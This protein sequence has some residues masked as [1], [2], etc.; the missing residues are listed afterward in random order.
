MPKTI[1]VF[2]AT[3]HQGGAVARA[4]AADSNNFIVRGITR[5]VQQ[6]VKVDDLKAAGVTVIQCDLDNVNSIRMALNDADG[7][8]IVTYTDFTEPDCIE[9]EKQRGRNI[10][11]ACA[12]AGVP[13]VIYSTQ[14]HTTR[15]KG[16]QVR[17]LVAKAEIEEYMKSKCL[18]MTCFLVPCY[19]ENF[20]DILKPRRVDRNTFVLEIPMGE[21]SL[22]LISVE[23]VGQVART[24]FLNKNSFLDKTISLCGEKLRISE[25]AA[26]LTRHLQPFWIKDKP[27]T[28]NDYQK[29]GHPWSVDFGNM[30]EFFVRHDQRYQK[31]HT[32]ELYPYVLTFGQWTQMNSRKL[33]EVFSQL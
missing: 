24:V 3:G 11:D 21:T 26:E 13:H 12:L 15:V 27:I 19:Y 2:G 18:P 1:T 20:F 4:L 23:D 8:F 32:T 33:F 16:I 10:A 29:L 9:K 31:H 14:L 17:H 25:I 6:E 7:C 5:D 22:D 28:V 30:F